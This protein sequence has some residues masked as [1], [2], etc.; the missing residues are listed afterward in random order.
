M[1]FQVIKAARKNAKDM[2][3][4]HSNSWKQAYRGIIPNEM[5]EAFTPEKRAAIFSN[6]IETQPEEYYLFMANNRPAGIASLSKCH[7]ESAPDYIGEIYSFYFHPD[8]WGSSATHMGF[9]F[10][11]NRLK[12]LGFTQITIWV[13][14]DNLRAKRF[15]E[16]NG[17]VL[18]GHSQ[19]IEIGKKLLEVRYSK[20]IG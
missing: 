12:A 10:C 4:I 15:Y 6:V 1:D 3:F 19:E 13:L 8:F 18:D 7:E 14:N 20:N 11:I 9:Q 16:K 17:F 2:G 5:I